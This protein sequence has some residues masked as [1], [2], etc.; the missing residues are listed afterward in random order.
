MEL[1][2]IIERKTELLEIERRVLARD[3]EARSHTPGGQGASDGCKLD[4]FGPGAD[5]QAD[6]LAV[7][8]SP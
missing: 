3:D 5:H 7:Q 1:Y 2:A 6:G 8:P 4:R